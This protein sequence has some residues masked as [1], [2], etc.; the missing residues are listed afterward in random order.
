MMKQWVAYAG[1]E[2]TIEWYFDTKDY[3]QALEYFKKQP[4]E[5]QRKL[6]NLIIL[7]GDHGKIFDETKFRNEGDGIY[8]FKPQPDR[9]L[10]FFCKGKKIIITNA[11]MKKTQK[12]PKTEKEHAIKAQESF[13]RRIK[14]GTYYEEE[15]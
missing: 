8:A 5:K 13:E 6:L 3:S 12:L 7:I 15:S 10:C 11:F 14:E 1:E 4:K 2:F 9:Y